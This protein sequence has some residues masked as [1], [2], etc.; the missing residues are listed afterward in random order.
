M[1]FPLF[2]FCIVISTVPLGFAVGATVAG[3]IKL[4][5]ALRPIEYYPPRGFSPI[6]VLI[7]Y[8]GIN[9]NT[10]NLFN[11]MML[12][13]ASEGFIK[14]REDCRRGLKITKL[15]DIERP[16]HG[17]DETF[18][19]FEIEKDLFNAMFSQGKDFYT[20]AAPSSHLDTY[21]SFAS[22]CK[23][24][25]RATR[26]A[27]SKKLDT[28]SSVLA[29]AAMLITTIC[30]GVGGHLATPPM[31][32]MMIFPIV[33]VLMFRTTAELETAW[34][35]MIRYPFFVVWGGAPLGV[36]L[37]FVPTASAVVLGYAVAV[38]VVVFNILA[39]RIDI[40]SDETT[41][42]YGRICAFRTFL[43][44]AEVDRLE[45]L[46]EDDPDYFFNI[47]PYCYILGITEKMKPKFDRI[48][49]EGPSR[50]L[51]E[52]RDVLMF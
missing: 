42:I 6:D 1:S 24:E 9:T 13:W 32:M 5:R 23:S 21:K 12:Y 7:G 4:R 41:A 36:C 22:S 33:A 11:P 35:R 30:V 29:A 14:I 50:E 46:I 8:R 26:T 20:L 28:V 43:L 3:K 40:R 19:N 15:K 47:L 39:K 18:A 17:S 49:L 44:E 37:A 38:G 10:R 2:I 16:K 25:A 34:E 52:L 31:V 51:G 45:T 27:L 48:N